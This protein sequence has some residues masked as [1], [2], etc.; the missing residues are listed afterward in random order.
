MGW[1]CK[2]A[3]T[4]NILLNILSA[5]MCEVKCSVLFYLKI[6]CGSMD[7]LNGDQTE[8]VYN[9]VSMPAKITLAS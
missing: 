9:G 8:M 1:R 4:D 2:L 7:T 6:E 5:K 3:S